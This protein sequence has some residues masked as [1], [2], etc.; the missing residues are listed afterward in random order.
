MDKVNDYTILFIEDEENVRK[1]YALYLRA[2]F[3]EVYE[4]ANAEKALEIYEE[5]K[6][7]IMIVDIHLPKQNGIEFI[8]KIRQTD[9]MVKIIILTAHADSSF[10]LDAIP[11]KLIKYLIKPI[12]RQELKHSLNLAINEIEEYTIVN[13]KRVQLQEGYSWDNEIKQI[14]FCN[15]L[16][17]LT[18]KEKKLLELLFSGKSRIF[19][20]NEIFEYV[21]DYDEIGSINGLKNLV[22]R[23][24]KKLPEN[25]IVNIFKEGYKINF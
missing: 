12:S 17:E 1:N 11:L 25:M 21:W 10:L 16:I 19:T 7:N 13:N 20:Y 2:N 22:T 18:L 24:R 9:A 23:L 15:T 5:K 3:K 14:Y 4:A 8:K 6:P